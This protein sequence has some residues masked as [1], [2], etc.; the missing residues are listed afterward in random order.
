MD[1]RGVDMN[2]RKDYS[3]VIALYLLVILYVALVG[4]KVITVLLI[5]GLFACTLY[6]YSNVR[7]AILEEKDVSVS[8]LLDRLDQTQ[9]ESEDTYKRFLSLS[10]TLGSG[11]F[12]VNDEGI[13]SF[14]NKDVENYFDM[15]INN[16]DYKEL[17]DVKPL[18]KF[19]NEAYLLE[20]HLRKQI[21]Y[22][23]RYYDLTSTPLF[24]GDMFA[25]T[26]VLVHDITQIETAEKFQKRFTADVSHE[27]RTPLSAIKGFSEIML[28][29]EDMLPEDKKEFLGLI[30]KE[31]ERMEIIL[32]DLMVISRL[33]RMDYEIELKEHNIKDII[34]ETTNLLSSKLAEKKLS[35]SVDV[36]SYRLMFDKYKLSQVIIN[37]VKNAINYTDEGYVNIA[38]Y[39]EEDQ[40]IIK[41]SDSGIGILPDNFDNIFKR[42]YR[43]DK[44]RSRDTGGSGLG[45]SISKN[46]ILKH[47]GTI[48]VESELNKGSIFTITLPI[49]E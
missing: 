22:E 35:Q 40:Y 42:F 47:G 29:D 25:G 1:V 48:E 14:S 31:S 11:V 36:Q 6:I 27:L 20:E 4:N 49:K 34:L 46:V 41:I 9:K 37:I 17:I 16:K 2:F 18:Y 10:K 13:I 15:N 28:R 30:N 3:S 33:D 32:N 19:V 44:A 45:L 5:V 8:N 23:D 24:E 26:L 39:L 43:V 12:M 38:G 21:K 7:K